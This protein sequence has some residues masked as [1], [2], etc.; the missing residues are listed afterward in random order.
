MPLPQST[1]PHLRKVY[2]K[3]PAI[4]QIILSPGK[5]IVPSEPDLLYAL[6]YA[7][8]KRATP[9]N[10]PRYLHLLETHPN[11]LCNCLH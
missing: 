5:A 10:F 11:R 3:L 2:R 8:S 1:E 9:Q 6:G 7:L 4:D